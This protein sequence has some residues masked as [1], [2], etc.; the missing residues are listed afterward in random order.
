[1]E[2]NLILGNHSKG[3]PFSQQFDVAV[4]ATGAQP[5]QLIESSSSFAKNPKGFILVNDN[6]QTPRF[7]NVF[8]AGDCVNLTNHPPNFPP[9]AGVFAVREG[10]ILAENLIFAAQNKYDRLVKYHPQSEFL[11]LINFSDGTAV[12][13]KF[14]LTFYGKWVWEMKDHID[15]SFMELFYEE[16]LRQ[17]DIIQ[18]ETQKDLEAKKM[19]D[20]VKNSCDIAGIKKDIDNLK[21][22]L[23]S[24]FHSKLDIIKR[25]ETDLEY[26]KMIVSA[27]Q[28]HK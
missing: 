5:N 15:R 21:E 3:A 1:V 10:P 28:D 13:A 24:E 20:A 7:P 23:D 26:R 11:K 14:G 16:N 4:L 9:K 17:S 12:G 6:L 22:D 19:Q 25:M 27:Y 18:N 2:S 8:G